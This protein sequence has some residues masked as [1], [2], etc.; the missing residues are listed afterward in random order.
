M[1]VPAWPDGSNAGE[2]REMLT[3]SACVRREGHSGQHTEDRRQAALLDRLEA[4][5]GRV[6]ELEALWRDARDALKRSTDDSTI[7]AHIE[8]LVHDAI[9]GGA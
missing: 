1:R 4:A 5:E 6:Q 9:G 2:C 8:I 3:E 7:L